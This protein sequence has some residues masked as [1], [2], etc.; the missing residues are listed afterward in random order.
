MEKQE[1]AKN[2]TKATKTDKS[3]QTSLAFVVPSADAWRQ[4]ISTVRFL[5]TRPD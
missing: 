4:E 3:R 1:N 2:K 5:K